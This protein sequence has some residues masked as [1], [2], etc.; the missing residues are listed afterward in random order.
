MI[1]QT[2]RQK[3]PEGFQ[4]AE[5]LIDKGMVDAVVDRREIKANLSVADQRADGQSPYRAPDSP[6]ALAAG[7]SPA[8]NPPVRA[9]EREPRRVRPN[10]AA[11]AAE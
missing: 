4:R 1:E 6:I 9:I 8:G 2:I 10:K 3:L 11:R 5:F 7:S